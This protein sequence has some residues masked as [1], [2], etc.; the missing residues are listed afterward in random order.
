MKLVRQVI[1][2]N[3]FLFPGYERDAV[4][5][6]SSISP[7]K[8]SPNKGV[9]QVESTGSGRWRGLRPPP[10]ALPGQFP[11]LRLHWPS[12]NA[13]ALRHAA[14]VMAQPSLVRR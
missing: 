2:N 12:A 11:N 7:Q 4:S 14:V 9:L 3:C 6:L 8:P 1:R 10:A 13:S 5:A